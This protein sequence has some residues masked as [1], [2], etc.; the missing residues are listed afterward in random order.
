MDV[1]PLSIALPTKTSLW[2]NP[3]AFTSICSQLVLEEDQPH[4]EKL[5]ESNILECVAKLT[6]QVSICTN[7]CWY[8]IFVQNI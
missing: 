1:V 8:D 7:L 3:S 5:G 6:L 4:Y 2:K